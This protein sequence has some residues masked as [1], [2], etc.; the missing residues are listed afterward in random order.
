VKCAVTGR[1]YKIF[2]YKGKQ[3]RD[4]I[5]SFDLVNAFNYFFE[6]PRAGEVY[7]IGGGRFSN[8]SVLE[9]INLCE[10]LSG[11]KFNYELMPENR[12]GDHIWWISDVS[13]FKTH[14]PG[15][16]CKYGIEDIIKEIYGV[17]VADV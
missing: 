8:I 14:Y 10:K 11:R 6:N 7:N 3:V 1:V 5:H 12:I 9:A 2:G 13:K 17:Q 15:W 4:N 16:N